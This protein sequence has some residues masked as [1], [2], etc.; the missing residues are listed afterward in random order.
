[1]SEWRQTELPGFFES[2]DYNPDKGIFTYERAVDIAPVINANLEAQK[3]PQNGFTQMR[4]GA[5]GR[6][7]GEIP[8]VIAFSINR[9]VKALEAQGVSGIDLRLARHKLLFDYLNEHPEYR[10]VDKM[11]HHTVNETNIVVK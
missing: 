1:M 7:V 8:E 10:V 11:V 4:E 3:D 6:H 2:A 9:K 5:L